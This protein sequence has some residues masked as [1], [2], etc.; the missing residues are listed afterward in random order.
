M[1][2]P[3][4]S[5]PPPK[6]NLAKDAAGKLPIGVLEVCVHRATDLVGPYT[7]T[8]VNP[9]KLKYVTMNP[10]VKVRVSPAHAVASCT[11]IAATGSNAGGGFGGGPCDFTDASVTRACLRSYPVPAQRAAC[12]R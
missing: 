1:S 6:M 11:P 4:E 9:G 8:K 2:A 3:A 7:K 12:S 5:S 10:V